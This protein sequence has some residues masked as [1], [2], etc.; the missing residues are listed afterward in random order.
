MDEKDI[1]DV[2]VSE[3]EVEVL[4]QPEMFQTTTYSDE[5]IDE[6]VSFL[7]DCLKDSDYVATDMSMR[8]AKEIALNSKE[9]LDNDTFLWVMY[10]YALKYAK[11]D[12]KN[13][14]RY[15]YIRMKNILDAEEG[16]A[17]QPQALTFKKNTLTAAIKTAVEEN[18]A[19]M[20][21]VV[22]NIQKQFFIMEIVMLVI[23]I[24]I[25]KVLFRYDLML[26]LIFTV[27]VGFVNYTFTY[28]NLKK[29]YY[30]NQTNT[31]KSYCND[32]ELVVFDEPV[33]LS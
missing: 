6:K 5:E 23:F 7:K 3:E 18:T 33:A 29:K 4:D 9:Y 26:T 19:F 14:E 1:I 31:S 16:K 21:D 10:A 13:A 30:I 28:R 17:R 11:E 12:N 25:I 20:K 32:E 8:V 22:K 2:E 27:I 15:C 24:F